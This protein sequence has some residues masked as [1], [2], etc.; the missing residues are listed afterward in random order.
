MEDNTVPILALVEV[1]T[2]AFSIGS[3]LLDQAKAN[4]ALVDAETLSDLRTQL[5]SISDRLEQSAA[6]V[7]N[8]RPQE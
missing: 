7:D 3:K 8:Y 6:D 4:Q 1:A 5:L 2:T